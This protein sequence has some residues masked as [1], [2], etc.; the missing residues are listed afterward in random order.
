[1]LHLIIFLILLSNS[2]G[3]KSPTKALLLSILPGGGQFYTENYIKG[4]IFSAL[5]TGLAIATVREDILMRRAQREGNKLYYDYHLSRRYDLLWWDGAIWALSMTD[6]YVSAHF[7]KFNE[8]I[9]IE[10]GFR[11]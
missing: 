11:F 8:D 9:G 1:M 6:A 10:I 5:Q 2:P 7:Y 3:E 4:A